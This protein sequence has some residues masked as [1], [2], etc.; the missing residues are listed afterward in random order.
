[1]GRTGKPTP[2]PALNL[3]CSV[4]ILVVGPSLAGP[5]SRRSAGAAREARGVRRAAGARATFDAG[6][7]AG[8]GGGFPTPPP[9]PLVV[10][11]PPPPPPRAGCQGPAPSGPAQNTSVS[12][13]TGAPPCPLGSGSA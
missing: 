3:R 2:S 7:G 6:G 11:P 8:G 5:G 12:P 4:A 13:R 10:P 9:P 1:M